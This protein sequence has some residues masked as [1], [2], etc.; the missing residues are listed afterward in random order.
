MD[1]SGKIHIILSGKEN[2]MTILNQN[3]KTEK[4]YL[5]FVHKILGQPQQRSTHHGNNDYY[6]T[7]MFLAYAITNNLTI[8]NISCGQLAE[9]D[10]HVY[11]LKDMCPNCERVLQYLIQQR[12]NTKIIVSSLMPYKFN[13]K[14]S[15]DANKQFESPEIANNFFK[16]T[17]YDIPEPPLPIDW[18]LLE[19]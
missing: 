12:P 13:G 2:V 14:I 16:F 5:D 15:R 8:D 11:S 6:H 9:G 18:N 1:P 3:K 7:E 10:L 19:N 4:E 17:F